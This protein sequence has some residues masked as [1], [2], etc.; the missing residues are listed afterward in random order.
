MKVQLD[1]FI[2]HI[3]RLM[4]GLPQAKRSLITPN[5]YLGGQYGVHSIRTLKRLGITAVVSMRTK[6][7][8]QD[9]KKL[10]VKILQLKTPDK[11]APTLKNL[12]KGAKFIDTEIKNGGKVYIHCRWGEERGPTMAIAYL[13]YTGLT[14]KDAFE[15][16]KKTR[17]FINPTKVQRDMLK[18][19]EKNIKI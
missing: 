2:D 16:V 17:T 15:L 10:D 11:H 6:S 19:F 1:R 8:H 14:Y 5:I 13:I 9:L 3:W 18:E 7:A 4:S 12:K